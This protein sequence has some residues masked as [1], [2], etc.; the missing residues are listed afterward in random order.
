MPKY[1][2]VLPTSTETVKLITG[3]K[4]QDG[5]LD[6]YTAPELWAPLQCEW[7]DIKYNTDWLNRS[8]PFIQSLHSDWQ[9][10]SPVAFR[11]ERVD[12]SV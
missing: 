7:T 1:G 8:A 2:S 9:M 4:A 11:S 3:L 10:D 5:H 12:A 6:F